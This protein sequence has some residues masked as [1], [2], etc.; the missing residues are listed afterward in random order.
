MP[1]E[2]PEE[3]AEL[4]N[5]CLQLDPKQRPSAKQAYEALVASAAALAARAASGLPPASAQVWL[6]SL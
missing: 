3:V 4:M 6:L 1:E 5:A 2:V